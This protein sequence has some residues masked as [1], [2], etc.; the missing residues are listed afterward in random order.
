[1]FHKEKAKLKQKDAKLQKGFAHLQQLISENKTWYAKGVQGWLA[2]I[3]AVKN[4]L[5]KYKMEVRREVEKVFTTRLENSHF[6]MQYRD[7]IEDR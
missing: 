1:M 5:A 6:G 4:Q 2:D 3:D 7:Q